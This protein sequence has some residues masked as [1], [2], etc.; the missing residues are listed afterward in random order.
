[1]QIILVTREL[2]VAM[3]SFLRRVENNKSNEDINAIY[4]LSNDTEET[5]SC[6]FSQK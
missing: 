2:L 4:L 3:L 1:M 5:K 6:L